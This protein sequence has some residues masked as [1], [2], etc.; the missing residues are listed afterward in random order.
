MSCCQSPGDSASSDR[1]SKESRP[2][3]AEKR[4]SRLLIVDVSSRIHGLDSLA[5]YAL[6]KQR[7][8]PERRRV[9]H[10]ASSRS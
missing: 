6:T 9:S 5:L 3:V 2:S 8:R 7:L 4:W 10:Q 1:P